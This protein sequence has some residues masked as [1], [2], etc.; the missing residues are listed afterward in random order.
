[1]NKHDMYLKDFF[2]VQ[3]L[4]LQRREKF[5]SGKTECIIDRNVGSCRLLHG[6]IHFPAIT[7]TLL[8]CGKYIDE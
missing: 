1:M 8:V 6:D 7:A 2:T 5:R 4:L 3:A